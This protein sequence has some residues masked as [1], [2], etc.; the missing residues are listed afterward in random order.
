MSIPKTDKMRQNTR[1]K[2][3]WSAS[4]TMKFLLQKLEYRIVFLLLL[5]KKELIVSNTCED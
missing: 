5:E 2:F 4:N 1:D 3:N